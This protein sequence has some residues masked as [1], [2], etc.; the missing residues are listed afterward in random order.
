MTDAEIED[1]VRN[2][3]LHMWTSDGKDHR[4]ALDFWVMAEQ[5]VWELATA[6]A[7]LSGTAI[8]QAAATTE[9]A[10]PWMAPGYLEQIRMLSYAMWE[11]AGR[12]VEQTADFWLAAERHIL[13]RT[14]CAKGR[15]EGDPTSARTGTGADRS[16]E[17]FSPQLYLDQI[18]TLAYYMWEAAGRHYGDALEFWLAAERQYLEAMTATAGGDR[19]RTP[20]G[21]CAQDPS[22]PDAPGGERTR[23]DATPPA[24]SAGSSALP[25]DDP[26]TGSGPAKI[27]VYRVDQVR[28]VDRTP[29]A[30]QAC[31]FAPARMSTH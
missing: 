10:A 13:I 25:V 14:M 9:R 1:R 30:G 20:A 18:R 23:T 29:A 7:R 11:A 27:Q 3:A 16:P 17:P 22:E 15:E 31:A 24:P 2:L 4:R 28:G 26:A 8:G 19:H 12:Q 21:A 5:M 6:T